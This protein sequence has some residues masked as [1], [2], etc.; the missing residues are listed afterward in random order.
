[1]KKLSLCLAFAIFGTLFAEIQVFVENNRF[2]LG[3]STVHE[4]TY[5]IPY[6]KLDF[7]KIP[8]SY[9]LA[10]IQ[11]NLELLVDGKVVY[12]YP[13]ENNIIVTSYE[14]TISPKYYS[15]KI[16]LSSESKDYMAR[17]AF[18][19]VSSGAEYT[20]EENLKLLDNDAFLSDLEISTSIVQDTTKFM[21]K[22]HRGD[23]LFHV[24]ANHIFTK[25][26]DGDLYYY[27]EIYRFDADDNGVI[28]LNETVRFIKDDITYYNKSY[29]N[30]FEIA[31]PLTRSN[32]IDLRALSEG[33]YTMELVVEDRVSGLIDTLETHVSIKDELP[34]KS[35]IFPD[36]ADEVTLVEYFL[37]SN[38]KNILKGLEAH[39]KKDFIGR[40]WSK[41]DT[42]KSTK[43]NEFSD[44][45]KER[46]EYADN[47]FTVIVSGWRSDRGRVY[48]KY[49]AP[50][51]ITYSTTDPSKTDFGARDYEIWKYR[52]NINQ[53]YI[54]LDRSGNGNLRMI[55]S[56]NDNSESSLSNWEDF[57]DNDFDQSGLN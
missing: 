16:S 50:D 40:F 27:Y 49:G 48:I 44:L 53:T 12:E 42:N 19:E 28:K 10:K 11:V 8:N 20:W 23:Q 17:I 29:Y 7:G 35:R 43:N 47:N 46:K 33:Y 1:M 21:E 52:Q 56:E 2:K 30:E 6:D 54:F 26:I 51:D 36:F 5:Q 31:S 34:Y 4:I 14:K 41:S 39:A 24:S 22:F 45:I 9:Y 57:L 55:Y 3:S 37:N 32:D 38:Q 15:D 25:V 18:T 13:F